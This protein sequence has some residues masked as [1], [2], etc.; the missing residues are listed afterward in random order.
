MKF[1]SNDF[2]NPNASPRILTTLTP[3]LND[4]H[5]AFE[6]RYFVTLYGNIRGPM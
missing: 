5:D 6:R 3:T 2:T 1:L 4:P